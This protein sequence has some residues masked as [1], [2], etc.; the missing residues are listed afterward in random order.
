M[1]L[2]L[3]SLASLLAGFVDA[4]VGGG[5]LIL[6]PALFAIFP[7]THPAS[8]FG[9]NKGASVWGTAMAA[10][11]YSRRVDLHWRALL[12]AAA[13]GLAGGFAGAWAVTVVSADFLRK[14]LPFVLLGVLA[15]TLV[16]KELGRHHAPRLAPGAER[17][18]ACG[19]GLTLG[20]YDG[21]F[22]PGT[23][24]FFVFL[25]VRWLGYDFLN[26]SAAAKLLNTATNLAALALFALKGHV[27]WHYALALALANVAGSLM[28]THLALRHGAA[29]VRVV[30]IAVV[31]ALILKTGYDA[32]LR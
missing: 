30:F 8:L 14:L 29:F 16:K 26:A 19:I 9:L 11:Q 27:W 31:S 22:G 24:S 25:F 7:T 23:G 17:L 6:V 10:L 21:F 28:G 3:M 13:A 2:L 32:F 4:I 12:P 5:G 18:V 20:F 1:E 15:Y